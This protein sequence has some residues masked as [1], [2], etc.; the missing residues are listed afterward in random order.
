MVAAVL[1]VEIIQ[2]ARQAIADEEAAA[3]AEEK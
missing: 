2:L 3:R 1:P